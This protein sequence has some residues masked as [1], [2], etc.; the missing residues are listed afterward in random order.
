MVH[1]PPE[2]RPRR[3]GWAKMPR[4]PSRSGAGLWRRASPARQS[5]ATVGLEFVAHFRTRRTSRQYKVTGQTQVLSTPSSPV[6][7]VCLF[8]FQ[9]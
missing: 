9:S 8:A 5:R 3:E 7:P 4:R 6:W 2:Q 1:G